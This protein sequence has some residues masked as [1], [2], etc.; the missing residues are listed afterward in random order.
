MAVSDGRP[1]DEFNRPEIVSKLRRG[2]AAEFERLCQTATR[3]L[4]SII[5]H[6]VGDEDLNYHDVEEIVSDTLFA[7]STAIRR[8]VPGKAKLTTW[9]IEIARNKTITHLKARSR[10]KRIPP[11]ET[12]SGADAPGESAKA[13][14][15]SKKGGKSKKARESTMPQIRRLFEHHSREERLEKQR[16]AFKSLDKRS[17]DI[18]WMLSSDRSDEAN[19]DSLNISV[20]TYRVRRTRALKKLLAAAKKITAS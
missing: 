12:A 19:A 16:E 18:L 13:G 7:A 17:R 1:L 9:L 5:S 3:V 11:R 8:F 20:N 15:T 4:H 2:D 10:K 6:W 14:V